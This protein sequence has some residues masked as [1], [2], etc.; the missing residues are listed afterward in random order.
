MRSFLVLSACLLLAGCNQTTAP[1]ASTPERSPV[2]A[3]SHVQLPAG[4]ACT[5]EI[6]RF[7]SIINSDLETGNVGEKV[8][9]A[10]VTEMRQPESLCAA[11]NESG[12]RAAL[13]TVQSRHG[14]PG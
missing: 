1:Q 2:A 5:S 4:A 12:A 3:Q 8:H 10:M 14:Y 11:G 7:R 9:A 13:R 6:Q